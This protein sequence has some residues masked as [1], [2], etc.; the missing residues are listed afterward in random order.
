MTLKKALLRGLIGVPIGVTISYAITILISL[1]WG[2][3]E[4]APVVPALADA[5][6]AETTAVALQFGL[7]CL[8][9]FIFAFA[10]AIWEIE[11][12]SLTRQTVCHFLAITLGT[13]PIAWVCRWAGH[14][15]GGILGYFAIFAAAYAVLWLFITSS[16]RK[17]VREVNQKL[18][19]QA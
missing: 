2:G 7:S 4:Y 3:G 8:M 19:K 5:L 10:S 13:L 1:G 15:P 6:G 17:K 11:R 9:G 14:I 18:N 16:I 12:W